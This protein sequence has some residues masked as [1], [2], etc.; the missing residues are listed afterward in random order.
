M[1]PLPS[2]K[3]RPALAWALSHVQAAGGIDGAQLVIEEV[4]IDPA[5]DVSEHQALIERLV[6]DDAYLAVIG[7]GN[8]DTLWATA[9]QLV[10]AKKPVVSFNST[11]A[12]LLRAYGGSG[13]VWRTRESDIGQTELLVR[14]ARQ[15]GAKRLALV[16]TLTTAG[17]TFFSWFGFFARDLGYTNDQVQIAAIEP[18]AS[19]EAAMQRVLLGAPDVI[20]F[21]G[22]HPGEYQ[23]AA[24]QT[25]PAQT[26]RTPRLFFADTGLSTTE[27]LRALGPQSEG[28]EGFSP[29]SPTQPAFETAFVDTFAEPAPPHGASEYDALLLLAYGLQRSHG[30]GKEALVQALKEVVDGR[31]DKV[32]W[33][34]AGVAAALHALRDGQLPDVSGATGEL[35]FEP[36]LYMDLADSTLARWVWHRGQRE[37]Q[38]RYFTGASDFST[39]SG[40]LVKSRL[41]QAPDL[42]QTGGGYV[43]AVAKTDTWALLVAFSTGFSNYRH[44]SDLLRQYQILRQGGV[45]DDHIVVV[46]AD[47]AATASQNRERGVLRNEIGGR[48][49]R[50]GFVTDYGLQLSAA[51][52]M[53][54]LQGRQST[55]TPQ[56][57][58]TT[59]GSNLYVYLVGHGGTQGMP[60]GA[61][62]AAAGLA[63]NGSVLSPTL[64]RSALCALR[65]SG[66][67]RRGLVVIESCFGGVFGEAA[68]GGLEAGCDGGVPLDGV[69]LLSAATSKENSFATSYDV[70]NG[71][72][73]AD[74]FS[75]QVARFAESTPSASLA[76][77]F[78]QAYVGVSGSHVSIYNTATAGSLGSV[79][80]TE[81]L[82][83]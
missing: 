45:P 5:A 81:F 30:Q 66:R 54:V 60:I 10:R 79:A 52:M 27:V 56:V 80:L 82:R 15:S 20:F 38:D 19:C 8:S 3:P 1:P 76:A 40:A 31:G 11:A 65:T 6:Q 57:L 59:A 46:S 21:A 36:G 71:I 62:T 37:M 9:D 29:A 42:S 75:Q 61:N 7:P 77:L 17:Q 67:L 24:Q 22:G 47:D 13:V 33:D 35:T 63:G 25:Q 12:D 2:A 73:L 72:W 49:L 41:D 4:P 18:G 16:T 55:S 48:D 58:R 70:Q 34:Q 64:L 14:Y 32:S 53:D 74:A 39:S 69:V 44:Q 83:N 26:V 51:E 50:A 28:V 68:A 23:C 78:K 43:P